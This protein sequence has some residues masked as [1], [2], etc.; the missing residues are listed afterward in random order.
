[1]SKL[2]FFNNNLF[3]SSR[4]RLIF[5]NRRCFTRT[6]IRR[7][8]KRRQSPGSRWTSGMLAFE[9]ETT[10]ASV[11]GK[12]HVFHYWKGLFFPSMHLCHCTRSRRVAGVTSG[13]LQRTVNRQKQPISSGTV[14]LICQSES[15]FVDQ[16]NH[17][18]KSAAA[19]AATPFL[20]LS[21]QMCSSSAI[22]LV[23]SGPIT[24]LRMTSQGSTLVLTRRVT[25]EGQGQRP[26]PWRTKTSSRSKI[27]LVLKVLFYFIVHIHRSISTSTIISTQGLLLCYSMLA[28]CWR[29]SIMLTC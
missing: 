4:L 5:E 20:L 18:T 3:I 7:R 11:C 26:P 27:W 25:A 24:W 23:G 2:K 9:P 15:Q 10:D 12:K 28:T 8:F 17:R 1:M 22:L 29:V 13:R 6:E 14:S 21:Q 16:S 19:A